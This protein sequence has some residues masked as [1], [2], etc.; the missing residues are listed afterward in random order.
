MPLNIYKKYFIAFSLL[1]IYAVIFYENLDQLIVGNISI[2]PIHA[3]SLVDSGSLFFSIEDNGQ[4]ETFFPNFHTFLY[5]IFLALAF[6]FANFV[7]SSTLHLDIEGINLV[8]KLANLLIV[9]LT[10]I[11][12]SSFFENSKKIDKLLIVMLYLLLPFSIYGILSADMDQIL[13]PLFLLLGYK[14]LQNKSYIYTIL[15]FALALL[16]KETMGLVGITLILLGEIFI[17]KSI[18]F[19]RG[20]FLGLLSLILGITGYFV[21]CKLFNLPADFIIS[22]TQFHVEGRGFDSRNIPL[23][24][25]EF[26]ISSLLAFLVF[27]PIRKI[28]NS[29]KQPNYIFAFILFLSICCINIY[30]GYINIR[31]ISALMPIIL[32]LILTAQT[33]EIDFERRA[34]IFGVIS[35]ALIIFVFKDMGIYIRDLE[36]SLNLLYDYKIWIAFF[37]SLALAYLP[38]KLNLNKLTVYASFSAITFLYISNTSY[39]I[40]F[41]FALPNAGPALSLISQEKPLI[42][43][44]PSSELYF[45]KNVAHSISPSNHY[46]ALNN[47]FLTSAQNKTIFR[48]D[49]IIASSSFREGYSVFTKENSDTFNYFEKVETCNERFVDYYAVFTCN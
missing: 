24:I 1:I 44:L 8:I 33:L 29:L 48:I 31:Y 34:V 32:V 16:S 18:S 38:Q 2:Y 4:V 5:T 3:I 14:F 28:K 10:G 13:T 45:R 27:L 35:A 43:D 19:W 37:C 30:F 22:A 46:F 36:I 20:F 17:K 42:S 12:F 39:Q 6:S 49:N 7:S 21:L 47:S 40:N 9:T 23:F 41:Q 25:R 26:L 15:F 11:V